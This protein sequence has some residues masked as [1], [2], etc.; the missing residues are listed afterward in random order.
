[1]TTEATDM[2]A[3]APAKTAAGAETSDV[4]ATKATNATAGTAAKTTDVTAA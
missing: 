1:M 3:D 4:T 2:T